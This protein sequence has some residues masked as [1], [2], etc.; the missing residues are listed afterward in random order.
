MGELK[1]KFGRNLNYI[2]ISVTDRCNYRCIYCMP[3]N[4]IEWI[5]H[6]NILTYEEII[7]LARV[8]HG[9][10]VRKIRFTG[11]EPL[12]RKGIWDF[13]SDLKKEVPGIR[14][15]LTTNGSLIKENF[16]QIIRTPLSGINISLDT[17][18]PELFRSITRNGSLEDVTDGIK[19]LAKG[20]DIPIKINTVLMK[21]VNDHEVQ[22]LL[23]FSHE[24]GVLLRLIEFM[25][26]DNSIWKGEMFI[27][28]FQ[29]FEGLPDPSRWMIQDN[30]AD[31]SAG[32]AKYY[33]NSSTGQRIGIIA[34]VT[35]HFCESCNRLRV[36]ATGILRP[37]L[38]SEDGVDL[39]PALLSE[40]IE[41]IRRIIFKGVSQKPRSYRD[42]VAG[43]THMSRIGG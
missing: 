12:V 4:G 23:E 30:S 43:T 9:L 32:P 38:F 15:V 39:R 24:N 26:L 7:I 13:L 5:P 35:H 11:G 6:E 10:G 16:N 33:K 29:I 2:R 20:S 17:L 40:D 3:E 1:D 8:L 19:M 27:P 18:K 25:P 41:E 22:S 28:A 31:H 36:S 21:G 37:C 34:A 42:F 14:T